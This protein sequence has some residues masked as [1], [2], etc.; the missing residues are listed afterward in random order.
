MLTPCA[1]VRALSRICN[2]EGAI[3]QQSAIVSSHFSTNGLRASDQF[4]AW[5]EYI[6]VIFDVVSRREHSS[7]GFIAS[8]DAFQLGDILVAVSNLEAQRYIRST[9]RIHGDQIDHFQISLYTSGGW[10]CDSIVGPV[11]GQAG[12]IC[13]VDLAQPLVSDEPHSDIITVIVPR[14]LLE[15]RLPD[16]PTLHGRSPTGP[17]A[18]V[19]ADYFG[20]LARRLPILAGENAD[21]MDRATCDMLV[22]CL[23]P[24]IANSQIARNQIDAVLARRAKRQIERE[25]RHRIFRSNRLPS[26]WACRDEPCTGSL[27]RRAASRNTFWESAWTA[28]VTR[29]WIKPIGKR[30]PRSRKSMAL[31]AWTTFHVYSKID[32]AKARRTYEEQLPRLRRCLPRLTRPWIPRISPHGSGNWVVDPYPR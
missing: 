13:V 32:S 29:C 6:S 3:M 26:S 1:I 28:F 18:A 19:L 12:Q 16:I 2:A 27:N 11:H 10:D 8:I 15:Y 5:R 31:R 7:D 23:R 22:A 9:R 21:E 14:D 30:F 24:S 25:L 17:F 20:L 4:D